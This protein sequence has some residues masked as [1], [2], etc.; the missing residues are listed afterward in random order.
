MICKFLVSLTIPIDYLDKTKLI[1][2]YMRQGNIPCTP[3]YSSCLLAESAQ[4]ETLKTDDYTLRKAQ[5][6]C[7][8][9]C[10]KLVVQQG[11]PLFIHDSAN[12]Q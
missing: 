1:N 8:Y 5:G 2:W 7:Y 9:S 4:N 6:V 11:E 3:A 10:L 12:R